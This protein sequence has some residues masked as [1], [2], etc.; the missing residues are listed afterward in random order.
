MQVLSLHIVNL[1]LLHLVEVVA[2]LDSEGVR[3]VHFRVLL[4]RPKHLVLYSR[5]QLHPLTDYVASEAVVLAALGRLF[6]GVVAADLDHVI[7]DRVFVLIVIQ[8]VLSLWMLLLL[9]FVL[10]WFR[11]LLVDDVIDDEPVLFVDDCL[12]R[13]VRVG[14]H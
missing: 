9:F 13:V 12:R 6:E 5:L 7:L 11:G 2:L 1:I 3:I 4:L 10:F 8:L 14:K